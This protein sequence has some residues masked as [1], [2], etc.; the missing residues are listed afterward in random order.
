MN[1]TNDSREIKELKR[2]VSKLRLEGNLR[3]SL[4]NQLSIQKKIADDAKA[5]AEAKSKEVESISNKLAKYLSPQIHEQ[6]FSGKQDAEVKS[7]RKKEKR[8]DARTN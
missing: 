3:K 6:I 4:S 7:N 1:E 5:E 8:I 2:E